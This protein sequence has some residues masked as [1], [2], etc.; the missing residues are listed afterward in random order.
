MKNNGL[1]PQVIELLKPIILN[2]TKLYIKKQQTLGI[3]AFSQISTHES[4]AEKNAKK[5]C[6]H[7]I[8]TPTGEI[9]FIPEECA[10]KPGYKVCPVCD[11]YVPLKFEEKNV[12]TLLDSIDVLNQLAFFGALLG[13]RADALKTIIG[14][15]VVMPDIAK[16]VDQLNTYVKLDET[17][18]ETMDTFASE[19][20]AN[21]SYASWGV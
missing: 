14:V 10:D 15:K 18:S 2:T 19:Y 7:M 5:E 16:L 1:H 9:E 4:D 17:N 13:L 6:V 8:F 12:E 20:T 11:R 21:K 3:P